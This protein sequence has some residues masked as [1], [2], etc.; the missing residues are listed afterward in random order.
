MVTQGACTCKEPATFPA[1]PVHT[2]LR[3]SAQPKHIFPSLI[4]S[5]TIPL[6]S[7]AIPAVAA[8]TPAHPRRTFLCPLCPPPQSAPPLR[9]ALI[10]SMYHPSLTSLTSSSPSPSPPAP[11]PLSLSLS[12]STSTS[13]LAPS[14]APTSFP[15]SHPSPSLPLLPSALLFTAR[16]RRRRVLCG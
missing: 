9:P 16:S 15:F 3:R 6:S 7:P 12:L 1:H 2:R 5:P 4:A 14:L 8:P 11:P 10:E 13:P